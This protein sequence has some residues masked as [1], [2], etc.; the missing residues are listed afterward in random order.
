MD[1]DEADIVTRL[2]A[3]EKR[4]RSVMIRILIEEAIIARMNQGAHK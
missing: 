4:P 3:I 1:P 2:A